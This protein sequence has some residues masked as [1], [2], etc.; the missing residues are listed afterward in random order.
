[1]R[2]RPPTTGTAPADLAPGVRVQVTEG[3]HFGKRGEFS[4]NHPKFPGWA[5]IYADAG[6][7]ALVPAI[8]VLEEGA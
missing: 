7:I 6:H 2:S 4:H 8:R 5:Y 3:P 1:M